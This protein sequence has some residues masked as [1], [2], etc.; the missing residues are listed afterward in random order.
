MQYIKK[1]FITFP[2]I[3]EK[4]RIHTRRVLKKEKLLLK[5]KSGLNGHFPFKPCL[6]IIINQPANIPPN[7]ENPNIQAAHTSI[8]TTI[9]FTPID[10]F[11]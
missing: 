9:T 7:C 10:I 6:L 5:N 4:W 8:N 11:A 3:Y 2:D 1:I